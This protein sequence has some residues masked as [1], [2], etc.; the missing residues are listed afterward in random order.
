[1]HR[2]LL[3][4]VI[5]SAE[6]T[7]RR[8]SSSGRFAAFVA[9]GL[10]A[11]LIPTAPAAAQDETEPPCG[12]LTASYG[13]Y[14]YRKERYGALGIVEYAHFNSDVRNLRRGQSG[15]L[16]SDLEYVLRTSPNHHGA[17]A[18]IAE[19]GVKLK[20]RQ[21]PNMTRT[22]D[23]F[24]ERAVRFQRNDYVVRMLYANFLQR[25][26]LRDEA[27]AALAPLEQIED[28]EAFTHQ[29]LG[30][31][32]LDLNESERALAQAWKA[33]EKGWSR[34]GLKERL[35]AAGKWR[36]APTTPGTAAASA[37]EPASSAA[38]FPR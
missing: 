38:Q 3:T 24:F 12:K 19:W 5:H 37:T 16:A 34:P 11:L 20:T 32:L 18:A 31:L 9:H 13:P 1:M 14:D 10:I 35:Q 28:L 27:L 4:A 7:G 22:I 25:M 29:N 6:N 23:C 8:C 36:D 15:T 17:L 21:P 26:N 33:E 2:Q 30:M